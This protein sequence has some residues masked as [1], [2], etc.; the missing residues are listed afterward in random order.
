M[1]L[2][3]LAIILAVALSAGMIARRMGLPAMV[4]ELLAGVVLGPSL[5]GFALPGAQEWLFPDDGAPSA[6]VA[7]IGQFGILL[8]VGLAATELDAGL[9]RKRVKVVSSVS[10]WSFAIPLMLGIGVGIVVPEHFRGADTSVAEFALLLGAAM[11]LSAIP[12]IA[13]ILTD[14]DLLRREI[15]QIT[16]AA[17]TL[18]DVGAWMLVAVV[19]AMATVGLRGWQLPLTI[20]C[21]LALIVATSVLRPVVHRI[22][23]R[24]ES[25]SQREYVNTVVVILIIGG[26]ALTSALHLEAVLGAFFAGVLVGR[27][28]GAVLEPLQSVTATVLAPVF[29]ATAGLHLDLTELG[30]PGAVLL[31]IVILGMATAGKML[32]AYIGARVVRVGHWDALALGSGLNARGVVGIVV[33]TVGLQLGVFDDTVYMVV[34]LVALV[35]SIMAGP[36]LVHTIRRSGL[37]SD[38]PTATPAEEGDS[39]ESPELG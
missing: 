20:V 39:S 6:L 37:P 21:L 16:L 14:L 34:I 18:S 28:G 36:M 26:A 33:A 8:L 25:S 24:L 32:G 5:L 1:M 19:S 22:L 27:R 29:L 23:D 7:G 31:A 9:L 35:T 11:S 2:T 4:G 30:E 17:G 12:V 10:A 13:K 3:Q 38:R 15:G